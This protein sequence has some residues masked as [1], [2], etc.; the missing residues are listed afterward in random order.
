[1][2]TGVFQ[3]RS[4]GLEDIEQ[5]QEIDRLSFA[6][7]W[8]KS[9][10]KF[11]ISDNFRSRCWVVEQQP[12]DGAAARVVAMAVIWLVIDEAHIATIAVHPDYRGL[13]IGRRLM[14]VIIANAHQEKMLS[15]T[16][17]VRAGNRAAQD[18]YTSYGF[19]EVGRRP[20]YYQDNQEDALI[21][22]VEFGPHDPAP[23]AD[24][25]APFPAA[26]RPG[27]DGPKE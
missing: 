8:P 6:L 1:M 27:L 14:D 5:V 7:P 26:P 12:P 20:R 9:S 17:E 4:M 2:N 10:Y 21:M 19:V 22:T 3:I 18:L 24:A 25:L 11:E 15:A 16:L 13:G 23:Q